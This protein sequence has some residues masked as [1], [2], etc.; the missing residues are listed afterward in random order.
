MYGLE[1]LRQE[2]N[3]IIKKEKR[4]KASKLNEVGFVVASGAVVRRA[5]A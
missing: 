5:P 1:D 2:D 4:E 3:D